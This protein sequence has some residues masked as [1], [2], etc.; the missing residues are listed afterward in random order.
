MDMYSM[1]KKDRVW[2][3][4]ENNRIVEVFNDEEE[5]E[6]FLE[7]LNAGHLVPASISFN[8]VARQSGL[9]TTYAVIPKKLVEQFS[10]LPGDTINL[11]INLSVNKKFFNVGEVD[12]EED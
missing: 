11:S 10:I 4:T 6:N 5:A 12:E 1:R 2:E 8:S 7:K 3:I 9:Y